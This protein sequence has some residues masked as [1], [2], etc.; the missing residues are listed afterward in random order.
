MAP[1]IFIMFRMIN[2]GV[3]TW[4]FVHVFRRYFYNDFKLSARK[5]LDWWL[6]LR[7]TIMH[8]RNKQKELD[9]AIASEQWQAERL[10]DNMA[11]WRRSI[12]KKLL[13]RQVVVASYEQKAQQRKLVQEKNYLRRLEIQATVPTAFAQ[14]EQK[15]TSEYTTQKDKAAAFVEKT[16]NRITSMQ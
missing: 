12:Q 15:I 10:L 4:L 3:L 1:P 13:D 7:N 5:R 8:M 14:A 6:A 16:I 9:T 11:R 2:F